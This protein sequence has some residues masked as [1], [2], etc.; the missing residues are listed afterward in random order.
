MFEPA[1]SANPRARSGIGN[2]K[3]DGKY[4]LRSAGGRNGLPAGE[5]IVLI[6]GKSAESSGDEYV[7]PS[8]RSKIPPKYLNANASGL[9]ASLASG[10]NTIN[11]DLKP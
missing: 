5:Y 8:L 9:T 7:D 2:F 1:S 3:E 6:D 10:D 11:F 4:V